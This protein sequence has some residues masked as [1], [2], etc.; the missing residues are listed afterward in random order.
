MSGKK[1][2]KA[3][4]LI[5]LVVVLA[6]LVAGYVLYT[7][8]DEEQKEEKAAKEASKNKDI[9]V[10]KEDEKEYTALSIKSGKEKMD[11]T[12]E[13]QTWS[14]EGEKEFPLNEEAVE[15]ILSTLSSLTAK[16]ELK[17]QE[18]ASIA[19][20]GLKE[21]EVTIDAKRKDG[22]ILTVEIGDKLPIDGNYYFRL[23]KESTVY[24]IEPMI[25][26]KLNVTRSDLLRMPPSTNITV[27]Q[28]EEIQLVKLG[29][30]GFH[31]I[32][33][34]NNPYDHTGA[35]L[36][37][38]YT[39]SKDKMPINVDSNKASKLFQSFLN[40]EVEKAVDYGDKALKE[41]DLEKPKATIYMRYKETKDSKKEVETYL[42]V[43]KQD[44]N[45][46]YYVTFNND[47]IVYL[48]SKDELDTK[49]SY[50]EEDYLSDYLLLADIAK[51]SGL[52][53][54][55]EETTYD[56]HMKKEKVKDKDGKEE[57]KTVYYYKDQPFENEMTFK[58][59]YNLVISLK[60]KEAVKKGTVASGTPILTIEFDNQDGS[61]NVEQFYPYDE[62]SYLVNINGVSMYLTDKKAIDQF[63]E[64]QIIQIKE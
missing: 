23:G 15:K 64:K 52:K 21:P 55:T 53:I 63:K 29:K 32:Y 3:S 26:T 13:N 4:T 43:G 37:S 47:N 40:N 1:K 44:Q 42:H 36:F 10:L 41:Y 12:R 48:M 28:L 5:G 25:E 35:S 7:H 54:T 46:D 2:K 39:E 60:L 49:L 50:R 56:Y 58:Q 16:R 14:M 24:V 31:F 30:G 22:S 6:L 61:K 57:E 19:E 34:K 17:N 51:L 38:W 45:G 33:D 62:S 8:I 11:L 59:F 18:D 27:D 9:T 20:Y